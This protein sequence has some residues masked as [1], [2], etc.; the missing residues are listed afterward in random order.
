MHFDIDPSGF[1]TVRFDSLPLEEGPSQLEV[2]WLPVTKMQ[3]E[4]FLCETGDAHFDADWYADILAYNPRVS[5]G[6]V[7]A[8]N[9]WCAFLTGILPREAHSYAL[10]CGEGWRL[11]RADEWKAVL[12]AAQSSPEDLPSWEGLLADSPERFRRLLEAV[13]RAT[14]RSGGQEDR[15]S[16]PHRMLLRNGIT[17]WVEDPSRPERWSGLGKP[18][19]KLHSSFR[20][21]R[22]LDLPYEPS[23]RRLGHYGFRL[24]RNPAEAG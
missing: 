5:V 3:F 9:Y 17:E 20:T 6:E 18:H 23:L 14:R 7:H 8:D 15:G 13:D 12:D 24:V 21:A 22:D 11:P 2:G 10:W 4:R 16:L 1:P 19:R